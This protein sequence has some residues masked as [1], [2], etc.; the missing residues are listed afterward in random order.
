MARLGNDV[1]DF[2]IGVPR[3]ELGIP[4]SQ[5]KCLTIRPHPDA[6]MLA[7]FFVSVNRYSLQQYGNR[8]V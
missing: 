2:K 6:A 8:I 5:T 4:W 1:R 7:D 3:F